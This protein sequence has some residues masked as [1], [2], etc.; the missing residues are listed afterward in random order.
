MKEAFREINYRAATR[1]KLDQAKLIINEYRAQGYRMTNRQIYYQFVA[2]D[3][4]PNR[5]NEYKSLCNLLK[6]GRYT[7]DLDWDDIED[8][9]RASRGGQGWGIRTDPNLIRRLAGHTGYVSAAYSVDLWEAT[10]NFFP[11][12]WVEKNAAIGVVERV[13]RERGITY[14]AGVGY[15]GVSALKRNADRLLEKIQNGLRPIVYYLGDHDPSGLDMD[16]DYARR[17]GEFTKYEIDIRRI[18]LTIDQVREYNPPPNW[19]KVS[20]SRCDWYV[21]Q[22]GEECWELD[23]LQPADLHQIIDRAIERDFDREAWNKGLAIVGNM[24]K[25][26]E[27]AAKI[28]NDAADRAAK[29]AAKG[30]AEIGPWQEFEKRPVLRGDIRD[31]APRKATVEDLKRA[32]GL[33]APSSEPL[34]RRL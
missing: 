1:T 15:C 32:I 16:S 23:A 31:Y 17:L 33:K 10:Q 5:P 19:A 20:D 12:I 4:I 28:V 2:R 14:F 18:A 27:T 13:A 8:R 24:R 6:D 22:F 7:G 9:V 34:K 3:L 29:R 11:E 21:A 26:V 25:R 30:I